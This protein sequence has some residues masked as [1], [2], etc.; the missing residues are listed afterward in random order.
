MGRPII[1]LLALIFLA[2]GP[3]RAAGRLGEISFANSG[4]PAAQAPFIRG[5]A[6]LH[7]FE[8][9]D[10]A[11]AF[12]EAQA[13][14]PGFA[15]AW[16]GEAMT[17]NHPVWME[18][19]A[20]KARRALASFGP[21]PGARLSKAGTEREKAWFRAVETLYG[22]G[23]K[24]DRDLRYAEEM[25]RLHER[26]PT[27]VDAT[28]FYA[29][30]L[31]GTAHDGRDFATY[32]RAAALLE[33]VL[34]THP[35]HPGVL[36]YM[37]HS[38]DDPIHAPLGMRAAR[39]YGPLAAGAPH[40]LHMTSHI[41]IALGMWDEVIAANLAAMGAGNAQRRAK[42]LA[43]EPC[44]HSREWLAYGY[45]QERRLAQADAMIADCRRMAI[46]ELA[47]PPGPAADRR[48]SELTSYADMATRSV[49][50]TGRPA[51]PLPAAIEQADN[52]PARFMLAYGEAMAAPAD[53]ARL[54]AAVE[55]WGALRRELQP[56]PKGMAKDSSGREQ[57]MIDQIAALE[58]VAAGQADAG[59]A[60]LR[61]AAASETAMPLEF[62]PPTPPKP[63]LELLGDVLLGAKQP[64]Q[65]AQAY[66][67]ALARAPE[68]TLSLQGLMAAQE[69]RGDTAAADATRARIARYV[70]P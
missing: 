47:R 53:A 7:N 27:D 19:D 23:D 14:D 32:M 3:G 38:Y 12:R 10:A 21:T 8:Y 59:I 61:Q 55:R 15:M 65:A 30:S 57:L 33:E 56:A 18:Q 68:R 17:Y 58:L 40:A 52:G 5:L 13:A 45:L 36:H 22:P 62:G 11:I 46:A 67:A 64:D 31:L 50:D 29:L 66:A 16:W 28:A 20:D 37:I 1:L 9:G 2:P 48:W 39:L 60:A 44:G 26:F 43:P 49:I 69:A 34:P 24:E 54:R 4:A 63:T 6:L 25:A 42:G 41:F 35:N 51:E 70:R